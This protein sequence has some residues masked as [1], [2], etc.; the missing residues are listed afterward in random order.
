[1]MKSPRSN[2]IKIRLVVSDLPCDPDEF[3]KKIGINPTG[4]QRIGDTNSQGEQFL[5]PSNIW[6]YG[7]DFLS[8]IDINEPMN[9]ILDKVLEK[10]PDNIVEKCD[11]SIF[12]VIQIEN[13]DQTQPILGLNRHTIQKLAKLNCEVDYDYYIFPWHYEV[14]GFALNGLKIELHDC[15]ISSVET[16]NGILTINFSNI[17]VL[18]FKNYKNN[19]FETLYH[20]GYIRISGFEAN[21]LPEPG[22]VYDGKLKFNDITLHFLPTPEKLFGFITLNMNTEHGDIKITGELIEID[23]WPIT[24]SE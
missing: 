9:S 15:E 21:K 5:N 13:D 16:E 1:M 22:E 8:I 2:R 11:F 20:E 12:C 17:V 3:T 14:P 6:E 24:T 19:D 23:S 7:T 18:K 10:L 4:I